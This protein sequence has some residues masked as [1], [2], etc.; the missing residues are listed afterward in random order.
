MD[1][2]ELEEFILK[3][4]E[5]YK[6]ADKSIRIEVYNIM[7]QDRRIIRKRNKR[8]KAYRCYQYL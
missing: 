5:E 2:K 8:K 4:G 1:K 3:I 6:K 7:L